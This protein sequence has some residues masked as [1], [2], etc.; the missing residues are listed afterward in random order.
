MSL[1]K[2]PASRAYRQ[3]VAA[4]AANGTVISPVATM[5]FGTGEQP[6]AP[7][8]DTQLQAEFTRAAC[9]KSVAGVTVTA[10]GILRGT[11][12]GSRVTREVGVFTASGVLI[13][14]RVLAPKELEPE[15]EIE[16]EIQIEY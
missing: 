5:A 12:S 2:V 9:A 11:V 1:Q 10:V 16:V 15:A 6:Y 14:R 7:E 8:S 4:A 3:L 13:G